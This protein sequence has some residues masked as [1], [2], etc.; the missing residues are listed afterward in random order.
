MGFNN[1]VRVDRVIHGLQSRFTLDGELVTSVF[2]SY[3]VEAA[4]GATRVMEQRIK[5]ARTHTGIE[6]HESGGGQPGRIV[7]GQL[8]K[9]LRSYNGQPFTVTA[10]NTAA[11]NVRFTFG[12][13]RPVLNKRGQDY[14]F[15]Q[16]TIRYTVSGQLL[17]QQEGFNYFV[18]HVFDAMAKAADDLGD[19][20]TGKRYAN[21]A[22]LAR[23]ADARMK[24]ARRAHA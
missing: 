4:E 10:S 20:L 24:R 2:L 9:S 23:Q 8:I 7:T 19:Y 13:Q 22:D 15:Y 17:A 5:R 18:A 21:R 6:R 3:I 1:G 16:E 12:Y 14:T 11:G